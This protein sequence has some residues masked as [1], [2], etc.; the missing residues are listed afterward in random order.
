M[1]DILLL[2]IICNDILCSYTCVR[3]SIMF[4]DLFTEPRCKT[5]DNLLHCVKQMAIVK[6]ELRLVFRKP[7]SQCPLN[8]WVNNIVNTWS[9]TPHQLS[10]ALLLQGH[11]ITSY[12]PCCPELCTRSQYAPVISPINCNC[13]CTGEGSVCAEL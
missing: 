6:G 13:F 7:F 1:N 11:S 10:C 5:P 12:S 9:L 2:D 8:S 3:S 4:V